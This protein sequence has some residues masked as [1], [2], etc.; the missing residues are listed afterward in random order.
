[1]RDIFW[2]L[3]PFTWVDLFWYF[4]FGWDLKDTYKYNPD[5]EEH[6]FGQKVG[7]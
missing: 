3:N 5:D 1:M 7:L 6:Y 2:F 4:F